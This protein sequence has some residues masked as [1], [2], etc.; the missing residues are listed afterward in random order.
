MKSKI[1]KHN[2]N[3]PVDESDDEKF[4]GSRALNH[5]NFESLAKR[6]MKLEKH[7]RKLEDRLDEYEILLCGVGGEGE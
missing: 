6:V 4:W 1:P 7:I 5:G 2:Y 3:L